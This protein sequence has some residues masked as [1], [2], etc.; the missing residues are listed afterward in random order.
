QA[1]ETT[2][3]AYPSRDTLAAVA[4]STA[5]VPG[6]IHSTRC[7]LARARTAGIRAAVS[8][9]RGSA[10]RT[11]TVGGHLPLRRAGRST[12]LDAREVAAREASRGREIV[13]ST[14]RADENAHVAELRN[15]R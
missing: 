9:C 2:C 8:A 5:A 6:V 15:G 1:I 11:G 12:G 4:V 14:R 10:H 7:M 3:W 13:V